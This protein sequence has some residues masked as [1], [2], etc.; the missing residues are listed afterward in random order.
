MLAIATLVV[1][2]AASPAFAQASL[3]SAA[4][5]HD[6]SPWAMFMNADIIVK[7]VMVGLAFASL[8]TWTIGLAKGLELVSSKSKASRS[9][10]R[11]QE[12]A[13]L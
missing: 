5:P 4:L 12:A 2:C 1:S 10:R 13:D 6:L 11:I 3:V 8:V 9:L 7:A